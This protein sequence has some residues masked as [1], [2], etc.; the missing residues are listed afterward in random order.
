MMKESAPLEDLTLL[1]GYQE[2]S[3]KTGISVSQLTKFVSRRQVRFYKPSLKRTWFYLE[4]LLEDI[5]EMQ[6]PKIT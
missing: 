2:A 4:E 3:E 6:V 1:Q 5:K